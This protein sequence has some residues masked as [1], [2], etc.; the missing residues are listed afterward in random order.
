MLRNLANRIFG[1]ITLVFSRGEEFA[2]NRLYI[3]WFSIFANVVVMLYGGNF[4]T[5]LLLKLGADDAYMGA[6]TIVTYAANIAAVFSP[7]LVER[8]RRRK[9]M[10]LISRS[11]YYVLLL[12]FITAI[13][14]LGIGQSTMLVMILT[15]IALANM[16]ASLTGS[17]MS[18]WHLQSLPEGVRSSFFANLNMIIG[19]LNMVLLNLAG[20][21]ADY[22]KLRGQEL[23]G[24][25]LLRC[26][27]CLFAVIEIWNLGR[28]KEYPYPEAAKKISL[29]D[30][31][32]IPLKNRKY[33]AVIAI[34][35]M[36][37]MASTIP[38]PFYQVYLLKDLQI[39]YSFLSAVNLLNIPVLLIAM[40]VW[41]RLISR[42][43]DVKLFAPLAALIS[44]HYLS[45]AFV[46]QANYQWLYPVSVFYF[47]VLAAGITQV[48]SLMPFKF[49]PETNQSNYLSF[50]GAVNT[51]AAL[52]GTLIGQWFILATE[53]AWLPLY[54]FLLGNKQLVMLATAGAVFLGAA[55]M[56]FINRQLQRIAN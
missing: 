11:I 53:T 34:I 38:G 25:I 48:A 6:I 24:I 41:G 49:I 28:I 21:F 14:Y 8:F 50:Y 22:F 40:P 45:L 54:G 3:L 13:P 4:F 20:L 2:R 5:G 55:V 32:R 26:A 39:N 19:I 10:L 52:V 43:G 7:L 18:V 56:F 1:D 17:G 46:T 47:F 44:L 15:I 36:W 33:L 42:Y 37:T 30:I 51:A 9:R 23:L 35:V 12:G 29:L 16:I 27:A 31:L